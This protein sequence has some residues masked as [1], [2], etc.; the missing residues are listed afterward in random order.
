MTLDN[1]TYIALS[2]LDTQQRAMDVIANNIANANTDGFKAGRTLFSDF[3]SQQ[4]GVTAPVGGK[5]LAYTQDRATYLDQKDGSL[6]STGNPLDVALNGPGFFTVSTPSGPRL[7]R[8]GKFGMLS[9]GRIA[10]AGGNVVLSTTGSPLQ[11]SPA[12]KQ[13][14]ISADG[15]I[16]TENGPVGQLG[17]VSVDDTNQ[18]VAEGGRLYRAKAGTTAVTQPKVIQGMVEGSNVQPIFEL[19]RMMQTQR[20]FQFVSQFVESEGQRQQSAI[21]KIVQSQ[22]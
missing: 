4:H 19:T 20:D 7:T 5:S 2:R 22:S 8:S 13:I 18:L 9:D 14:R 15:T 11:L 6:T 10:D 17:V 3:I 12:D 16:S 21:D 1:T